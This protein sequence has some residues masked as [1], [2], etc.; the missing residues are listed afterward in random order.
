MARASKS[1]GG[2][3][4]FLALVA[5]IVVTTSVG[6]GGG[7]KGSKAPLQY[8]PKDALA[9][10][11]V[12][13]VSRAVRHA[14]AFVDRF[15]QGALATT[16]IATKKGLLEKQL[17]FAIDKPDA[18]RAKGIE[19]KAGV[20]ISLDSAGMITVAMPVAKADVLD[21]YLRELLTK[22]LPGSVVF[23]DKEQG[24]LKITLVGKRGG[25]AFHGKHLLLTIGRGDIAETLVGL[26]KLKKTAKDNATLQR[27]RKR[28]GST[29]IMLYVDGAA[30]R[31]RLERRFDE[32]IKEASELSRKR[33]ES[34]K[35]LADGV[36]SYFEG[37]AVGLE[38]RKKM[39]SLRSSLAMPEAKAKVVRA[40]LSGKGSAPELAKFIGPDALVVAR[41]SLQ[42]KLLIDRALEL[43]PPRAKRRLYRQVERFER[44]NNISV[45]KDLLALLAGRYGFALF[46]PSAEALQQPPTSIAEAAKML[47]LAFF[48]QVTDA[49]KAAEMLRR[50]ERFL[51]MARVDVRTRTRDQQKVYTLERSGKALMSWTLAKDLLV[52]ASK[53]RL[54][55]TLKLIAKGG[56]NV[57]GQVRSSRA[58]GLLRDGDGNVVYHDLK[59][60]LDTARAVNLPTRIKLLLT[61][62]LGSLAKFDDLTVG[63]IAEPRGIYGELI[64]NLE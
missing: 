57:L 31:Q 4:S 60:A 9:V 36:L 43:I 62:L 58:K 56:K 1:I 37:W 6:C 47:Q 42:L 52:V 27:L 23:K 11:E 18:Y 25:W 26:T 63:L 41:G 33:F 49:K 39:L 7:C 30:A 45:E 10:I 50:L 8:V 12:P 21:K 28:L 20:A 24:G 5:A 61:P 35:E 44:R 19:P 53:E 32:R 38:L 22:Q 17:G 48:A 16:L 13:S 51:V 14:L 46:A 64:V 55:P 54:D 29:D 34:E 15:K 2:V 40:I 3:A 59:K